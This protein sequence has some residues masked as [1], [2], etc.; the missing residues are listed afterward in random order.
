MPWQLLV[1]WPFL[2]HWKHG[3]CGPLSAMIQ[4]SIFISTSKLRPPARPYGRVLA[5]QLGFS[6]RSPLAQRLLPASPSS[7]NLP[8]SAP[9]VSLRKPSLYIYFT[10]RRWCDVPGI[11][12]A[13]GRRDVPARHWGLTSSY[14]SRPGLVLPSASLLLGVELCGPG[15]ERGKMVRLSTEN[16]SNSEGGPCSGRKEWNDP[17]AR[18]SPGAGH[19]VDRGLE[20]LQEGA[21]ACPD[22]CWGPLAGGSRRLLKTHSSTRRWRGPGTPLFNQKLAGFWLW[23]LITGDTRSPRADRSSSRRVSARIG[24]SCHRPS[25]PGVGGGRR[26]SLEDTVSLVC[27]AASSG[28][29][30]PWPTTPRPREMTLLCICIKK[31][32]ALAFFPLL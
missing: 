5:D 10:S 25:A 16:H 18:I 14:S 15:S 3:S 13:L 23:G 24:V 8:L 7:W 26:A 31:K 11:G 6:A 29:G 21:G 17:G 1:S 28:Q 19:A 9:L 30:Q 12:S 20:P 32:D 27:S 4:P 2:I 22:S